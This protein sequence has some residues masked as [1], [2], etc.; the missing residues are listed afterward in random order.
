MGTP[1]FAVPSLETLSKDDCI[2]VL[3]VVTQPDKPV[4]RKKTLTA[5]P[6]KVCA[7]KYHILVLQ[8]EKISKDLIA[9]ETLKLLKPDVIVTVAYG[10]ILKENILDMAPHGVVNLHS[11]LLPDYRGPAPMNWMIINGEEEIGVTTMDTVLEVDAGDI[12]LQEKSKLG[13][14]ETTENLLNKST[15]KIIRSTKD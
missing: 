14:N 9:V 2:Q 12:L 11:S 15:L 7:E 10:Q 1:D 13:E 4:G 6:V 3:A 8:P 5:P